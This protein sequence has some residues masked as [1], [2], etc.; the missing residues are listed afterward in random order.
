MKNDFSVLLKEQ[1]LL[2]D[3]DGEVASFDVDSLDVDIGVV[4]WGMMA[5]GSST[6]T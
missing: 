1:K 6:V 2:L 4:S 3:A 5:V